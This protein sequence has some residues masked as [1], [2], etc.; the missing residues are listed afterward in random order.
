[1]TTI[2]TRTAEVHIHYFKIY[3][4]AFWTIR[5]V[6]VQRSVLILSKKRTNSQHQTNTT[7]CSKSTTCW[8]S[9]NYHKITIY[10]WTIQW[11]FQLCLTNL[12]NSNN[13]IVS[14]FCPHILSTADVPRLPDTCIFTS[15]DDR[16]GYSVLT[17]ALL[18]QQWR[19][20]RSSRGAWRRRAWPLPAAAASAEYCCILWRSPGP[21]VR[22]SSARVNTPHLS[23]KPT[24]LTWHPSCEP[25]ER[26]KCQ[27]I[28]P[29]FTEE[30]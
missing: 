14:P 5:K 1:M 22:S 18:R 4:G 27:K 23:P 29:D 30:H 8:M 26:E 2:K 25:T 3:V 21:A 20:T 9:E 19:C 16:G 10:C 12:K 11:V 13:R 17:L 28:P 24:L 6:L 7:S 15:C